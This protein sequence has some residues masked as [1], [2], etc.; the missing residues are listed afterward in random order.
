[1][2]DGIVREGRALLATIALALGAFLVMFELTAVVVAGPSIAKDLGFG[3]TGFAWLIDAYSL[4]F[5]TALLS[6][7][8]LADRFGH[9]RCMLTGN[10]VFMIASLAC[11]IA[12]GEA[13]IVAAR[14]LQGVGAAF[15]MTGA[16][17]LVATTFPDPAQ[18]ARAFGV[19]G[20]MSGI[21]MALGPSLG[22]LLAAWLGWRWVFLANVPFCVVLAAGVPWLIGNT[23]ASHAR[24]VDATSIMLVTVS[25]GLA[26]DALL[27]VDSS[28]GLRELCFAGSMLTAI[29]FARR[30]WRSTHPLFDPR[31]FA[32]PAMAGVAALLISIQFG[33]WAVLVYLPLFLSTALGMTM[34]AAGFA[35]LAATLPMLLV[36][37]LGGRLVA[38]WGW[39]R[40][41][42]IA[43]G[44][45]AI[46]EG[47]L[48]VGV[49]SD[50]TA[51]R[52]LLSM[53]GMTAIGVGAALA[54]P[55]LSGAVLALTPST[56]LGTASAITMVARQGGFAVSVAVAGAMLGGPDPTAAFVSLFVLASVTAL[57]GMGASLVLLPVESRQHSES[58]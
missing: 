22:G 26:V 33:Y 18:R 57:F 55:Q 52:F 36:P 35:L 1:L 21:A 34:D 24:P 40:L 31:V 12:P 9:R 23:G 5:T 56:H 29:L 37:L 17:A 51:A 27:R 41:F 54:N 44:M 8:A 58:S 20:V 46:G 19:I 32:N 50:D 38:D 45:I 53:L 4:A 6:A 14:V 28:L 13:T 2:S 25:L 48:L 30:Q 43:F 49:L 42:A 16:I 3:V 15:L 7:G 11:G 10:A 39:R 47:L